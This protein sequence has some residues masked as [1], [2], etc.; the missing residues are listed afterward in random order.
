MTSP[1]K[2]FTFMTAAAIAL[3]IG[4]GCQSTDRH[5]QL[6]ERNMNSM[7]EF[8]IC[9]NTCDE[10]MAQKLIAADAPFYTPVSPKPLI[11]AAGYLSV[12]KMMRQ[13][14]PDVHWKLEEMVA[15]EKKVAVRWTCSGTH[16]GP[17]PFYGVAASG[18]KFSACVMNFYYF[19][20][21]GKIYNDIAA[22]GLI[23][24]LRQIGAVDK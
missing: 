17:Q 6:T 11:G 14:F 8:E 23:A 24:I 1:L 5:Q 22:E 21:D 19:D 4:T 7:R 9:I 3:F 2:N 20:Q 18:K 15:D 10:T 16:T 12:V 13:S